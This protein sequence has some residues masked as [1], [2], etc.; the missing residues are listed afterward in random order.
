MIGIMYNFKAEVSSFLAD[1]HCRAQRERD[2]YRRAYEEKEKEL[3]NR[4]TDQVFAYNWSV[5]GISIAILLIVYQ[6]LNR[7]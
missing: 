1:Q 5:I 4:K 7:R 2:Y 6:I 3:K